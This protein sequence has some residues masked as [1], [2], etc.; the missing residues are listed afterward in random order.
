MQS[1]TMYSAAYSPL[2]WNI[3]ANFL[4]YT[5]G[6]D[7]ANRDALIAQLAELFPNLQQDPQPIARLIG[8]LIRPSTFTFDRI[9]AIKPAIDFS[10]GLSAPSFV[11][12]QVT[13][14]L[15]E[16]A[17]QNQ[18]DTNY[19]AGK[20]EVVAALIRLWLCTPDIAVAQEAHRVLLALLDHKKEAQEDQ[21]HQT[22]SSAPENLMWRRVFR[23]KDIYGS[24]FSICSLKTLERNDQLDKKD[25]TIAQSRLLDL[26]WEIHYSEFL[27]SSQLPDIE[28]KYNVKGGGL[29][30]FAAVHMVD[31]KDDVLMHETLIEFFA[32]LLIMIPLETRH[33]PKALDFLIQHGLHARTISYYL[34]P[35]KHNSLD[36]TFLYSCSARYLSIYCSR[37][38][39]HFLKSHSTVDSI[40]KRLSDVLLTWSATKLASGQAP[41]HDLRVL[42]SLPRAVLFPYHDDPHFFFQL[43][44]TYGNAA[45]FDTLATIFRGPSENFEGSEEEA[46]QEKAGARALYFLYIQLSP[47]LWEQVVRAAN[48]IALKEV[49]LAAIGLMS[50]VLNANW[51][52]LPSEGNS[53]YRIPTEDELATRCHS[54]RPMARYGAEAMISSK[55]AMDAI[56]PYLLETTQTFNNS[57]GARVGAENAIYEVAIAKHE[58][59]VLFH[60]KLSALVPMDATNESQI[61]LE[62]LMAAISR[63]IANGPMGGNTGMA[64]GRIATLEL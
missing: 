61:Q 8:Q 23:D 42:T 25:K 41:K 16:K 10:A 22:Q 40:L 39:A 5:D 17:G 45:L 6:I 48:I 26:L 32:K 27:W 56:I 18:G 33:S 52:L 3:E 49:A 2:S 7:E 37:S 55:S 60:K 57:V 34:E 62:A 29:L 51:A 50:A 4:T 31:F 63:Q 12:N 19:I 1:I 30:E 35:E 47:D 53:P 59:R 54:T 43:R 14:C 58:V 64:G 13:L 46:F 21:E 44:S 9:L 24:I 11:F 15:L 38:R 36:L 28:A 20:P